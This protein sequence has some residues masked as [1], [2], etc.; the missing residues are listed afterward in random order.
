MC[1]WEN[2]IDHNPERFGSK[3]NIW[4]TEPFDFGDT[5]YLK[6]KME[7]NSIEVFQLSDSILEEI[8]VKAK[9]NVIFQMTLFNEYSS[10]M[11]KMKNYSGITVGNGVIE[12]HEKELSAEVSIF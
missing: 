3:P 4:M 8:P 6:V 5:L 7:R 12:K 10:I 11:D 1:I 9:E 2:E